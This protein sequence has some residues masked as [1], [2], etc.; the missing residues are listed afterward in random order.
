MP[1]NYQNHLQEDVTFE[2]VGTSTVDERGLYSSSYSTVSTCKGRLSYQTSDENSGERD[3][4]LVDRLTLH[5]PGS[6][7]VKTSYRCVIDNKYY[8][9]I[10]IQERKNRFGD[11][12]IKELEIRISK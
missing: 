7:D 12:V 8:D 11:L 3:E 10:G 9:I 6:V 4:L 2:S 5:V 1:Y